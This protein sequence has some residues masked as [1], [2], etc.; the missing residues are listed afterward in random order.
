MTSREI[1]TTLESALASL[2]NTRILQLH[3]HLQNIKQGELSV[4]QYLQKAKGLY[5]ELNAAGRPLS[6]QDFNL[7]IFKG[8]NPT[9]QNRILTLANHPSLSYSELHSL[10][11]SHELMHSIGF[12]SLSV[13]D[14][15]EASP[16]ANFVQLNAYVQRN[17]SSSSNGG[18]RGRGRN[19]RGLGRNQGY[20]P[21]DSHGDAQHFSHESRNYHSTDSHQRCQIC[22]GA[23][24]TALSCNQRYNHTA[25]PSAHLASYNSAPAPF[26]DWFPDICA[27]HHATPNLMSLSHHENYLGSDQF[28]VGN[29]KGLP[30]HKIGTTT[31]QTPSSSFHLFNI[32]HHSTIRI[33][34][35]IYV[36]DILITSNHPPSISRLISTL[37]SEFA[38]KDLGSL[39]YF[40]GMEAHSTSAG[41]HLCQ[42]R[43]ILDLLSKTG[44]HSSKPVLT[45]FSPT[46]KLSKHGGKPLTDPSPYHQVV[47]ALQYLM[48]MRPDIAFAVNKA[49]QFMH[50]PTDEH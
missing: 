45:P 1:W 22:N 9:F 29:G 40:L 11:L 25:P 41:L 49:C 43:Y 38:L 30:I 5:D 26:A 35:L 8:L 16:Q 48:L 10:L 19:D 24:H 4:T 13:S 36:D 32:L 12:A 31:L 39:H 7:Y 42:R 2:S 6:L 28:Q 18:Y 14:T 3:L 44:M 33:Y 46:T 21:N 23:N 50:S 27:T 37:H 20:R 34:I 15:T 17:A 47:G